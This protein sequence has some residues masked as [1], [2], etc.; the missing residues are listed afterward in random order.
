LSL[1]FITLVALRIREPELK[2][3]FRVPGGLP[4]VILTGIFPISLIGLGLFRSGSETVLGMNGLLFGV[5]IILSGFV[6][7][8]ATAKLRTPRSASVA[9]EATAA[10]D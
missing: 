9:M 1:E 7:Y 8:L 6:V 4:G 5:I 2:R 10:G 3:G